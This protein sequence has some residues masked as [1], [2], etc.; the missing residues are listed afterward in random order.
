MKKYTDFLNE[1][2]TKKIKLVSKR[3]PNLIITFDVIGGK[4]QNIVKSNGVRF[5]YDEGEI[6]N[7]GIETWCC[8]NNYTLNGKDTCPEPKIFGIKTKDIPQGHPLRHIYPN[9]F[10]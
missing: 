10:K 2:Y 5:P 4:I 8:N 6:Y 7:R 3:N 1:N 9:K